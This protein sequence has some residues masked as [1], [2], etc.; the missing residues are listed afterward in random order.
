[1][2]Q[3]STASSVSHSPGLW[4]PM[5]GW[6]LASWDSLLCDLKV[7]GMT[8]FKSS[9]LWFKSRLRPLVLFIKVWALELQSF[10]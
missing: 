1:M 2:A 3:T 7:A 10:S 5:I 9:L 4:M 6:S 8:S